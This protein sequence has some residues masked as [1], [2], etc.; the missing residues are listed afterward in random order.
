MPV[1]QKIRTK[2]PYII[3]LKTH[4]GGGPITLPQ[5]YDALSC[6]YDNKEEIDRDME[7]DKRLMTHKINKENP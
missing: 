1:A 4:C 5:A 7:L 2:H 3:S 6:Y